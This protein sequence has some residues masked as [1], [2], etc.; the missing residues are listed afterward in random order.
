MA[1]RKPS[2]EIDADGVERLGALLTAIKGVGRIKVR[3]LVVDIEE[4]YGNAVHRCRLTGERSAY[5]KAI[6]ITGIW[7]IFR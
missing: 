7:R 3:Q 5:S 2:I 1:K 6:N 4:P